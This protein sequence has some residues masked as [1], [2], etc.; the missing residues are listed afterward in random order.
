MNKS[1]TTY[2]PCKLATIMCTADGVIP[3]Q[4]DVD[5]MAPICGMSLEAATKWARDAYGDDAAVIED[6][7]NFYL[8]PI[9]V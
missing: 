5:E 7:D 1:V 8:G 9:P 3:N 6:G 4:P 2:T